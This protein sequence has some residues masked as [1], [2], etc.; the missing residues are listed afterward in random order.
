MTDFPLPYL[1]QAKSEQISVDLGTH[2]HTHSHTPLYTQTHNCW[3]KGIYGYSLD[4]LALGILF[5]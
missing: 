5:L 2:T 4:L 1:A 3:I